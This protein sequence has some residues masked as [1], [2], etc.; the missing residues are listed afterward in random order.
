MIGDIFSWKNAWRIRILALGLIVL[1]VGVGTQ[2][3][4]NAF[5]ADTNSLMLEVSANSVQGKMADGNWTYAGACSVSPAQ[6]PLGTII[7]LYK[8]DGSFDRQCTAEDT[9]TTINSGHIELMMP[10]NKAAVR[11][12]G[13]RTMSAQILRWGWGGPAPIFSSATSSGIKLAPHQNTKPHLRPAT[14]G[15]HDE[16]LRLLSRP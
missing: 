13:I 4:V 2:V 8:S 6:F 11:Q 10:G 15:S 3:L 12:W 5:A 9:T 1:I 16:R 7:A 14:P